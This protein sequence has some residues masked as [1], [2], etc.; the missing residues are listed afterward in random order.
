MRAHC[1][2]ARNRSESSSKL[3]IFQLV[4]SKVARG[5][6][7]PVAP[8]QEGAS[9][10]FFLRFRSRTCISRASSSGKFQN[11]LA[12][13]KALGY[14]IQP[15]VVD[16]SKFL[17]YWHTLSPH[18]LHFRFSSLTPGLS[19]LRN[20]TPA[21]SRTATILPSVSVR[22]LTGPSKASMR[23]IVPRATMRLSAYT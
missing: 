10:P 1:P 11:Q 5:V 19:S 3:V 22:A 8:Y 20:A 4:R 16:Q 23:R 6:G 7:P 12:Y 17:S 18:H 9:P 2:P 15:S 14:V 21:F 13:G